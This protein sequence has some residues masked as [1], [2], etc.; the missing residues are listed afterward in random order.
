MMYIT[1][2]RGESKLDFKIAHSTIAFFFFY[3]CESRTE[4]ETFVQHFILD[5]TDTH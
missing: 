2:G 3:Q 4:E 1:E 5:N